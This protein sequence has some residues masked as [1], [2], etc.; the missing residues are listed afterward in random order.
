MTKVIAAID[1]NSAA[2]PVLATARAVANLVHAEL[3][4]VHVLEDGART[5]RLAAEAAGVPLR[6]VSGPELAS[7]IDAA[8]QED[9]AAVVAGARGTPGGRRPAG[10][11]A[12][13]L[14]QAL[15]K[16]VVV[17]PPQ[18]SAPPRL[19]RI[20]V[21]LDGTKEAAEA[22]RETIELAHDAETEVVVLHVLTRDSLPA[23]SDQPQ[24]EADAWAREFRARHL[25]R[26]NNVR[27]E[28][29][30]GHPDE[31]V[32]E[33]ASRHE[34]DLIALGWAGDLSPGK[35]RVVHRA[36]ERSDV[37]VLLVPV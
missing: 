31:L 10:H 6:T 33:L 28:T 11:V 4:A 32:L 35:A 17:V 1:N 25:P 22:L 24:H 30:V 13:A 16:P 3:E 27:F 12:L 20:L 18:A 21:P 19:A 15:H 5:A 8:E 37:P 34:V 9:V 23:F 2:R 7:L 26:P 14:I 36:L 29:R